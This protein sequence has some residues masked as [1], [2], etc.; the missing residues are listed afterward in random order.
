MESYCVYVHTTPSGKMYVG[1]TKQSVNQRWLKGKGYLD[2]PHFMNAI[3][4]YGWNN[5]QH[6]IV[7]SNLTDEQADELERQLIHKYDSTNPE[8]GYNIQLGGHGL[9]T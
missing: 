7:A 6:K 3:R 5:I 1:Q 9:H 4:K 2:N 8:I